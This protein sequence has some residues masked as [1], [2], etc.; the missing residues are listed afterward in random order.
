MVSVPLQATPYKYALPKDVEE[1]FKAKKI[2]QFAE[3]DLVPPRVWQ[4]QLRN[5]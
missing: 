1:K 3:K 5:E 2:K 4:I